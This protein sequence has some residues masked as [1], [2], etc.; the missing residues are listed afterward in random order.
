MTKKEVNSVCKLCSVWE[1]HGKEC[2]CWF[3]GK[4]WCTM[5]EVFGSGDPVYMSKEDRIVEGLKRMTGG[6]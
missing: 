1:E 4:S 5:R 2:W 3:K 6:V